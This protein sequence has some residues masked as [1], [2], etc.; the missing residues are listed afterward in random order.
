VAGTERKGFS[1]R[2]IGTLPSTADPNVFGDYL[3]SLG[4]TSRAVRTADGSWDIWVHNEDHLVRARDELEAYRTGPEDPRF[5]EA[6][7]KAEEVRREAERLERR[8]RK[9]VT[10][11]SGQWQSIQLRRRPLTVLIVAICTAIFVAGQVSEQI[12]YRIFDRL[13]FF[14]IATI[15]GGGGPS[16][17][18]DDIHRG[19]VWRLFTPVL[20]HLNLIHLLFNMWA[21]LVEGTIIETRRGT[22][23][24]LILVL[25][26]AVASNVGQ[27]LFVINFGRTLV[28]WGGFSGVVYAMF[29]YLWM[30]GRNEP[31]QGIYLHPSSVQIMLL[32][33]V[34]GFTLPGMRMANGAHLVGLVVGMLFGLARF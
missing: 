13:A 1:L 32:W 29:G 11:L 8:Y 25:L 16:H 24:M 5:R 23:T 15:L 30:K 28:P 6:A 27:Y 10:E 4:V 9:N 14:S 31:E 26:S 33:L 18:L 12:G 17:G 3:L 20:L 7:S 21:T 2:Q 34:L 19:E 22:R